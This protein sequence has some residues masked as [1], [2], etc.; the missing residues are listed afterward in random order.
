MTR[1]DRA[2]DR[3]LKAVA[4]WIETHGGKAIIVGGI[5]V[6]DFHEGKYK[7]KVAARC[8]GRAPTKRTLEEV[9]GE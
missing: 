3:L 6:Q 5:E 8:V 4:H 2:A 1:K 9:A 7:F